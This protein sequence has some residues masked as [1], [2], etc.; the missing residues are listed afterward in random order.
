M[1]FPSYGWQTTGVAAGGLR[2]ALAAAPKKSGQE[3]IGYIVM[4]AGIALFAGFS[5][6][7]PMPQR[8]SPSSEPVRGD[9][10][11]EA[12]GDGKR[13]SQRELPR[14]ILDALAEIDKHGSAGC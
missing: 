8:P 5:G 10:D 4:A 7:I 3:M 14:E 11:G 6:K 13:K 12:A 9:A 2:P 1:S